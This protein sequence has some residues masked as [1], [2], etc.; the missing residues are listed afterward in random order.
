MKI[1]IVDYGM[2][3]IWSILNSLD[4]VG[5][6]GERSADPDVIRG[7]DALIL[8]GVGAFAAA[9][10]NI[11]SSHIE[12]ALNEAVIVRGRPI[13]GVCLGMQLL[14]SEGKEGEG[15]K[16]LGW[17]DGTVEKMNIKDPMRLPHMGFNSAVCQV[18]DSPLYQNIDQGADFYFVH[19]YY[20]VAE[21]S[22]D[23]LT[24]TPYGGD[25]VSSV[26]RG[27][28]MG[29]QFHPEKSQ[30][31]GLRLLSNFIKFAGNC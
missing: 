30:S 8:P 20:F 16:G 5:G 13:L 18:K 19:S 22:D 6:E 27:N 10:Q 14:A 28:I 11:R 4:Y 23:I 12:D 1:T 17:L 26:A 7:A 2:G 15:A 21:N 24:L 3:N 31:N 29:V 9:M 25:F